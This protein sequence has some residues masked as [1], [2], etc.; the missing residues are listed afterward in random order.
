LNGD[1][2]QVV[3]IVLAGIDRY[4]GRYYYRYNNVGTEVTKFGIPA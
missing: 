2:K 3:N 4:L 1:V